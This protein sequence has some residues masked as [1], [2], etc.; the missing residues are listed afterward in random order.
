[1]NASTTGGVSAAEGGTYDNNFFPALTD[2]SPPG[3]NISVGEYMIVSPFNNREPAI[4]MSY[5]ILSR[6]ICH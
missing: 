6:I 3:R 4:E 2:A 1:M 5:F